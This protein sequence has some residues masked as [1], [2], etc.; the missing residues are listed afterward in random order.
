MARILISAGSPR[1][2]GLFV[3]PLKCCAG[4][5]W[6]HIVHW[7]GVAHPAIHLSNGGWYNTRWCK[8]TILVRIK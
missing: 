1:S 4:G 7:R 6:L 5:H 3:T 8:G 2:V